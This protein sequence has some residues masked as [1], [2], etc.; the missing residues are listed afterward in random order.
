MRPKLPALLAALVLASASVFATVVV[1]AEFREVVTDAELIVRGLVTDVR[2]FVVPGDGIDTVATIAV[3]SVLKGQAMDSFVSVRVPGGEV[4]S[5]KFVMVGA[6]T[7]KNGDR[8]VFFLKRTREQ[9]W[10]PIGLTMGVYRVQAEPGTGRAVVYP[11]ALPTASRTATS[12][13][14]VRGDPQ[15]KLLPVSEFE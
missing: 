9:I 15:R 5:T 6:P 12:A 2:S 14:V 13:T 3:E 1:P 10:R 8:A 11:P 4:G 7:F